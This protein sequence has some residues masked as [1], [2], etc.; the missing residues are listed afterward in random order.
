MSVRV[1]AAAAALHQDIGRDPRPWKV[2]RDDPACAEYVAETRSNAAEALRW[3]ERMT[4]DAEKALGL[5]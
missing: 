3:G 2:V 1:E 5:R 4:A